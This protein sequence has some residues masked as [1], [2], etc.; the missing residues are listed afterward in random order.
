MRL[1]T[2]P[3]V[4]MRRKTYDRI[5]NIVSQLMRLDS[6]RASKP[7]VAWLHAGFFLVVGVCNS[8]RY[9]ANTISLPPPMLKPTPKIAPNAMTGRRSDMLNGRHSRRGRGART[10]EQ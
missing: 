5:L 2:A 4:G 3:T 6:K 1:E 9:S 10:V 8:V 7:L